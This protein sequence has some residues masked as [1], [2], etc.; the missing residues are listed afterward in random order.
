[1]AVMKIFGK[2]IMALKRGKNEH[3]R[4]YDRILVQ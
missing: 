1:M 3:I 2:N 4:A